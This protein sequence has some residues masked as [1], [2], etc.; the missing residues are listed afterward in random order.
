MAGELP[1]D[2]RASRAAGEDRER[3]AAE[4]DVWFLGVHERE[5]FEPAVERDR[6]ALLAADG[7]AGLL[8]HPEPD[9]QRAGL[10]EREVAKQDHLPVVASGQ[11]AR[12]SQRT[13]PLGA[14]VSQI[15]PGGALPVEPA[16]LGIHEGRA[17]KM[18]N[19]AAGLVEVV[20]D[21]GIGDHGCRRMLVREHAAAVPVD[22]SR[23]PHFQEEFSVRIGIGS[24]I[25]VAE[26][27]EYGGHFLHADAKRALLGNARGGE[28]TGRI[29]PDHEP[30]VLDVPLQHR[31]NRL[32]RVEDDLAAAFGTVADPHTA[33]NRDL[34]GPADR[35]RPGADVADQLWRVRSGH[36]EGSAG[37][38][39]AA[40]PGDLERRVGRPHARLEAA[41]RHPQF[42]TLHEDVV[43]DLDRAVAV[44]P[45]AAGA[46]DHL[47]VFMLIRR[48]ELHVSRGDELRHLGRRGVADGQAEESF[49]GVGRERLVIGDRARLCARDHHRVERAGHVAARP[50]GTDCADLLPPGAVGR[51]LPGHRVGGGR[52]IKLPEHACDIEA[53]HREPVAVELGV[54][55]GAGAVAGV[56]G[57][58]LFEGGGGRGVGGDR[59]NVRRR[60]RD[61]HA[62][63]PLGHEHAA[64]HGRRVGAVGCHLEHGRLRPEAAEGGVVRQFHLPEIAAVDA[65]EAIVAGEH[66]VDEH[67]SRI[68]ELLHAGIFIREQFQKTLGLGDARPLEQVVLRQV[69]FGEELGIGGGVADGGELQPLGGEVLVETLRLR[70]GQHPVGLLAED[71][72]IAELSRPCEFEQLLVGGRI[73][74]ER[75]EPGGHRKV[76]ERARLLDD[77]EEVGRRE[78]AADLVEDDFAHAAAGF[79][80]G[81]DRR[82]DRGEFVV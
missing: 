47:L 39:H 48:A 42:A 49:L 12:V 15:E 45:T 81:L 73:P 34:A 69:V 14:A 17:A 36:A 51:P 4:L 50:V 13:A 22:G 24:E 77:A 26:L 79:D 20:E 72:G 1:G 56:E 30:A 62:E 71:D 66:G 67:P 44:Q 6:A 23:G 32:A 37:D 55:G 16:A 63:Q 82:H 33:P 2:R 18:K 59:L 43:V 8:L 28:D 38:R 58:F 57:E 53:F 65:G 60:G 61:V 75:G 70:V 11:Q 7:D 9:L 46:D 25:R 64:L 68:D 27:V 3:A 40:A 78:Q 35:E 41:A 19:V 76:V 54:A 74:E 31:V 29:F 52:S 21:A 80:V 10:F 5:N